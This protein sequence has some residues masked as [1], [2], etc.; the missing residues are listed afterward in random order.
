MPQIE[1][2]LNGR[3]Y[4]VACQEGEQERVRSVAAFVDGRLAELKASALHASDTQLLVMVSLLM[5]DELFDMRQHVK[6]GLVGDD[7]ELASVIARLTSQVE[8][9]TDRVEGAA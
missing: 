4:P 1:I 7:R 6:D 2:S 9:L 3:R 8:S 5:A